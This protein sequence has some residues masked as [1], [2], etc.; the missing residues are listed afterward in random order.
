[1]TTGTHTITATYLGTSNFASS[2]GTVAQAV[3]APSPAA[4]ALTYNGA[5][6]PL[7]NG[8]SANLSAILRTT[9]GSPLA[10]RTITFVVG[11]GANQQTCSATTNSVGQASCAV[12]L[13]QP[14]GDSTIRAS[15][16]GD[17]SYQASSTTTGALFYSWASGAGGNFV[18]GDRNAGV[19]TAVTFW[20]SQWS[21]ANT[22]SGGSPASFKG[23]AKNPSTPSVGTAWSTDPGNSAPP[24]DG[25]LA[26]YIG[27]IVT[28]SAS[29]N[30]SQISGNTV[31]IVVVRVNAGY[32]SNP[33]HDGTGT[34][35][36]IAG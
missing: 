2:S 14:T 33:G 23:F 8:S 21:K 18:I 25:P 15:F 5:S 32:S 27:V 26:A 36:A 35:V 30:G 3:S 10:S 12:V 31:H 11:S 1:L 17:S 29:K 13:N 20:G 16:A 4:T 9:G 19:G 28:S 7:A 22:L 24:P 6:G 34:V